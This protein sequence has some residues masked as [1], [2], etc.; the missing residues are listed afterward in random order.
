M[1]ADKGGMLLKA[2]AFEVEGLLEA[3]GLLLEGVSSGIAAFTDGGVLSG[4][5]ALI[6]F[7]KAADAFKIKGK[8]ERLSYL[9]VVGGLARALESALLDMGITRNPSKAEWRELART[10]VERI[11]ENE[12]RITD[13]FFESPGGFPFLAVLATDTNRLFEPY[14]SVTAQSGLAPALQKRFP[15]ALSQV[16]WLQ[17][18]LFA[19]LESAI[20]TPFDPARDREHDRQRYLLRIQR[21]F[22]DELLLGQPPPEEGGVL[23]RDVFVPL[24]AYWERELLEVEATPRGDA[25]H[26]DRQ[27]RRM[28]VEFCDNILSWIRQ[29][30]S[31]PT[32]HQIKVVSGGPGIGKS[33][34]LKDIACKLAIAGQAFPVFL[35]LSRLNAEG[36]LADGIADFLNR[37]EAFKPDEGP[38]GKY[39]A[40]FCAHGPIVLIFDGLD[41]LVAE[42]E[43]RLDITLEFVRE[44]KD[45]LRDKNSGHQVPR[46]LALIS[47]RIA[48]AEK[49]T[50]QL[51]VEGPDIL[52]LLPFHVPDE[53]RADYPTAPAS[54]FGWIR[55][56]LAQ[57]QRE[58]WWKRWK[59]HSPSAPAEL[60]QQ[61]VAGPLSDVSRD[62][63]L[64]YFLALVEAWKTKGGSDTV[65]R[66]EVYG[67]V[68]RRFHER[69]LDKNT[70]NFAEHFLDYDGAYEPVLQAMAM[71]AWV[72]K[73]SRVGHM[74]E[75]YRFLERWDVSNETRLAETFRKAVGAKNASFSASLA[76][77]ARQTKGEDTFEFLHKSFAE[78]LVAGRFAVA[79]FGQN[80]D[81]GAWLL[82]WC[83]HWGARAID[84]DLLQFIR[85]EMALQLQH[86]DE[87]GRT[88]ERLRARFVAGLQD[89]Y[90]AHELAARKDAPRDAPR[91][92]AAMCDWARNSEEALLVALN[93]TVL[94]RVSAEDSRLPVGLEPK[95]DKALGDL[96]HRLGRQPDQGFIWHQCLSG[97]DLSDSDL[98]KSNLGEADLRGADLNRADLTRADLR[99]ANLS[100]AN[101]V[102]A[103]LF[104]ANLSETK[105]GGAN[106]Y[107]AKLFGANV[108]GGYLSAANLE[109]ADLNRAHLPHANLFGTNLR[110]A[111]I[112]EANLFRVNLES[113]DLSAADLRHTNMVDANL[114]DANLIEADLSSADLR[115]ADLRGANLAQ[116]DFI[117]TNLL[118]ADFGR[119]G[120]SSFLS[121]VRGLLQARNL[122][123]AKLPEGW[124]V[125]W[126][127]AEK[128]WDIAT[129]D[130]PYI[131]LGGRVQEED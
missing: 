67:R 32:Q 20:R 58:E 46:V 78:Y 74:G 57:D 49:A 31:A 122:D 43:K 69:E 38:T 71:A 89:G 109:C 35:P 79:A 117:D 25:D 54:K 129:P 65:A 98:T 26:S 125:K 86:Q 126:N 91:T 18:A 66:N 23:L 113:A 128:A 53:E 42:G 101:L 17:P 16:W 1:V 115:R 3:A 105:L 33:S 123:A 102:E 19:D 127:E 63:L 47:G 116:A 93:A 131:E 22:Q 8:P 84:G 107:E 15:D 72:G 96:M 62:P 60:P 44:V 124:S 119:A 75:V 70:G 83:W 37:M 82:D 95:N 50:K 88:L 130:G 99:E 97:L 34:S 12:V 68:L 108:G 45:L 80:R 110:G 29:A 30:A 13:E 40:E 48:A 118:E 104:E 61:F 14:L 94:A 106:L 64:F 76:F 41:E 90:P 120:E 77:H 100:K 111:A 92:F 11:K 85:D 73:T 56:R 6:S 36:E 55:D 5:S 7:A 52:H 87:A 4:A 27:P 10:M 103:I 81:V 112:R 114:I 21:A 2:D 59:G 28:L 39:I 24:R 51:R 9:L 121:E